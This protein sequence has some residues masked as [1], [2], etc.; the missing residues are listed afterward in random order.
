MCKIVQTVQYFRNCAKCAKLFKMCKIVQNVHNL[1]LC[2][3]IV[4]LDI[5]RLNFSVSAVCSGLCVQVLQQSQLHKF[6]FD[7][8]WLC[9]L[10]FCECACFTAVHK[11][12]RRVA[13]LSS[14]RACFVITVKKYQIYVQKC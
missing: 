13:H 2:D 14:L 6:H 1:H 10:Q 11:F 12:H 7:F 5:T 4:S 3:G 8:F 9:G